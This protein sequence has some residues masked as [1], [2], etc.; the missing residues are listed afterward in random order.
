MYVDNWFSYAVV[1][2]YGFDDGL[3]NGYKLVSVFTNV[4]VMIVQ[5]VT[6]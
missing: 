5:V 3:F 1:D 2:G 6:S 4:T